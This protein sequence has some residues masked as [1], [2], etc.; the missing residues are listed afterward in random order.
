MESAQKFNID[1]DV[2]LIMTVSHCI[3]IW[4]LNDEESTESGGG[5]GEV[6]ER[7]GRGEENGREGEG[8]GGEGS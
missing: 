8:R 3:Y 2:N 7:G 6:R 1:S 4:L 5:R